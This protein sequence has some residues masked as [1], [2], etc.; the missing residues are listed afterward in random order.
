MS[1]VGE[2]LTFDP[3]SHFE[4]QPS[5]D[6]AFTYRMLQ[7]IRDEDGQPHIMESD[8]NVPLSSSA[9]E[10][11]VSSSVSGSNTKVYAPASAGQYF[12]MMSPS[13]VSSPSSLAQRAIARLPLGSRPVVASGNVREDR[14]KQTHKEVERRRRDKINAWISHLAEL[15]P[16]C[17]SDIKLA[18]SKCAVLAKA[19]EYITSLATANESLSASVDDFD[20]SAADTAELRQQYALLQAE[21]QLLWDKVHS[22]GIEPPCIQTSAIVLDE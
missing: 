16:D 4:L 21:N 18:E 8:S 19:C 2:S 22:N 13:D 12:V 11:K 9:A 15:V 14:R 7:V 10:N 6:A 1:D 5:D 17:S 20:A 3:N